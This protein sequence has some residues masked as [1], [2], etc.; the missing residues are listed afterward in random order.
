M[1][2]D[3][4]RFEALHGKDS[5]AQRN[6]GKSSY[7]DGFFDYYGP[8]FEAHLSCFKTLALILRACELFVG[9][10]FCL[11]ADCLSGAQRFCSV[12]HLWISQIVLVPHYHHLCGFR[13]PK[14]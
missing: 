3:A 13:L 11:L 6:Q 7:A 1:C 5:C 8:F 14:M 9:T 2:M 4:V 12:K 10:S